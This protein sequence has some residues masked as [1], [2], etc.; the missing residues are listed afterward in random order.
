MT[1]KLL[2]TLFVLFLFNGFVSA[3]P[4]YN[5]NTETGTRYHA[6]PNATTS[7]PKIMFDDVNIASATIGGNTLLNIT[8]VNFGV[9]RSGTGTNP[10][11]AACTVTGYV[12]KKDDTATLLKNLI[13]LPVTNIGTVNLPASTAA[14][15]VT[16][17]VSFGNGSSTLTSVRIDSGNVF[18]GFG[19]FFAGLSITPFITN[20]PNG[21]RIVSGPEANYNGFWLVDTDSSDVRV[22]PFVFS[23][24][25]VPP[26]NFFIQIFGSFS[27]V[28]PVN[29]GKFTASAGKNGSVDLNWQTITEL[30]NKGFEVERSTDGVNFTKIGWIEGVG[31]TNSATNYAFND[32]LPNNGMNYYRL[33][34]VDF[35]GKFKYSNVVFAKVTLPF[36]FTVSP[37][38]IKDKATV[39]LNLAETSEVAVQ[40]LS[41]NGQLIYNRNAGVL[42][43]GTTNIPLEFNG[44]K[45]SYI[46]RVI[47]NKNEV[48]NKLIVK[49]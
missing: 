32:N 12:S 28:A 8:Q 33:K 20:T 34:Q 3:Q 49:E 15:F 41:M 17:I 14:G 29:F 25:P 22:G 1:K 5:N 23:G 10:V 31:T 35:D 30:N 42:Q 7:N 19:T 21:I 46:V 38:P 47:A 11:T 44:S 4:I 37:N 24:S 43:A 40:V 9:R 45:G 13:H 36:S 39:Q 16:E 18:T 27:T 26:S 48:A 2:Q 6:A